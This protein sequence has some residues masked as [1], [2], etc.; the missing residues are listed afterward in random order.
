MNTRYEADT[1]VKSIQRTIQPQARMVLA[2]DQIAALAR[3]LCRPDYS[4]VDNAIGRY[5]L[6]T[7]EPAMPD[8]SA[9]QAPTQETSVTLRL[10]LFR[11]FGKRK[12]GAG[13]KP[14]AITRNES[15]SKGTARADCLVMDD[16]AADLNY[17]A[18]EFENQRGVH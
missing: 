17:D 2:L 10:R 6:E 15:E 18:A 3:E 1:T 8:P 7:V 4:D 11:L 5:L 14:A 16:D 9:E 13:E 12:L